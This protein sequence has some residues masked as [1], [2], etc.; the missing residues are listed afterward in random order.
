MQHNNNMQIFNVSETYA[1]ENLK[2]HT[3]A[4]PLPSPPLSSFIAFR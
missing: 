2:I 1:I 4:P 3:K